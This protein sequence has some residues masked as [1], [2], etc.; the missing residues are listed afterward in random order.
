M[1]L[2][3]EFVSMLAQTQRA[4]AT[5]SIDRFVL[6]LGQVASIKPEVLDKLDADQWAD[7]YSD[8]LGIDPDMIVPGDQVAVIRRQRAEAA[9]ASSRRSRRSRWRTRRRSLPMPAPINHRR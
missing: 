7:A 3:V 9:Q 5:N 4:V 1:E 6:S 2:N 8:M